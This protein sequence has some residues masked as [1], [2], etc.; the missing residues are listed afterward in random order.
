M[1]SRDDLRYTEG[2]VRKL[3]AYSSDFQ[4][5]VIWCLS[6]PGV[7]PPWD[8]G[9]TVLIYL[10]LK[11]KVLSAIFQR[12]SETLKNVLFVIEF[13]MP[14]Y[15]RDLSL[16]FLKVLFKNVFPEVFEPVREMHGV[17]VQAVSRKIR[18]M[19]EA[20]CHLQKEVELLTASTLHLLSQCLE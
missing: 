8:C 6:G 2:N 1:S 9:A 15:I 12:S 3:Y 14:L 5:L 20:V 19:G 4:P 18:E 16:C 11:G 13:V 17:L 10:D 7:H